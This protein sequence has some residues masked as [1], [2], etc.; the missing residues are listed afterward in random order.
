MG[1]IINV[2][3]THFAKGSK[4]VTNGVSSYSWGAVQQIQGLEK[5]TI[6]PIT[7]KGEKYGDGILRKKLARR[8]GYTLGIDINA[9]P[10]DVKQYVNGLSYEEGVETDDGSCAGGAFAFGFEYVT[11]EDE[12]EKIWF[13]WCE[14]DPIEEENQQSTSD[15]N[16]S[17]DT[18]AVTSYKLS[19]YGNRA[20]VKISSADPNV[21]QQMLNDFFT[22]VQTDK[23]ITPAVKPTVSTPVADPVSG[24]TFSTTQSVTLSCATEG[25]TIY[26]TTDDST[27]TIS[28]IPYSTP[29]S[30][31]AT[32]TIKAIAIKNGMQ[33]SA[34]MEATYTKS[35]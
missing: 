10:M 8:T 5:V 20:Y 17:S 28:S 13:I 22:K 3:N 24:A 33:N 9:L 27:P 35:E 7:A 30:L 32:T 16:I 21:T 34:V 14:A 29:I 12:L 15:I 18:L 23:T 6:T 26:Y 4:T 1:M 2:Q 19:E 11:T 31:S 25:A